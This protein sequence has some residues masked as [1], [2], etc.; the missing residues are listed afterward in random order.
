MSF[1]KLDEFKA[2]HNNFKDKLRELTAERA[3]VMNKLAQERANYNNAILL[4]VTEGKEATKAVMTKA[5][6]NIA[7]L[8]DQLKDVENRIEVLTKQ[9]RSVLEEHKPA[10]KETKNKAIQ[11]CIDRYHSKFERRLLEAKLQ[12]LKAI[13]ELHLL[14]REAEQIQFEYE[15]AIY[16]TGLDNKGDFFRF[17]QIGLYK[18]HEGDDRV[19]GV[20][21]RHVQQVFN[22]GS[23]NEQ[24]ELYLK[25]G[26]VVMTNPR[27]P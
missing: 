6:A 4:E 21:E 5:K 17:P 15:Q 18:V 3:D 1:N 23:L 14:K 10:L 27:S 13:Y 20:L 12:Y 22:T 24:F 26:E 9:Y 8:E 25:T 16:S 7:K 2:L 19:L 11:D